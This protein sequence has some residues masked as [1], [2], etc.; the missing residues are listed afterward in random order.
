MFI[1]NKL[2]LSDLVAAGYQSIDGE[3]MTNI[4]A[5]KVGMVIPRVE[6]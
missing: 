5:S 4:A 2:Y 1:Y 6:N 3:D